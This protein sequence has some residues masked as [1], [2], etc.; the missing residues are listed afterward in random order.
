MVEVSHQPLRVSLFSLTTTYRL[1]VGAL[2]GNLP[3]HAHAVQNVGARYCRH[4]TSASYIVLHL[5]LMIP[6]QQRKRDLLLLGLRNWYRFDE[7]PNI[8]RKLFFALT[9]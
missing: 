8:G 9:G 4:S 7:L 2:A 3:G 5:P 1:G 6:M